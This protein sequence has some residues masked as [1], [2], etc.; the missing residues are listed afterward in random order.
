[1]SRI[2]NVVCHGGFSGRPFQHRLSPGCSID[3]GIPTYLS[4]IKVYFLKQLN[5]GNPKR[6][7][8]D[9]KVG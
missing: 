7:G 3:L 5:G 4:D 1:M 8:L 9:L 2:Q 6:L